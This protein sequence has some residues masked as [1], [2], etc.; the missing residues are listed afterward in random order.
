M[1]NRANQVLFGI[2]LVSFAIYSVLFAACFSELPIH[3]S[4]L[5]QGFV[6]YFHMIPMFFLQLLLCRLEKRRWWLLLPFLPIVM[7]GILFL[8]AAEWDPRA[9]VIVALWCVAPAVGYGLAW[10]AY[11]LTKKKEG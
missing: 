6:F 4:P 8:G 7:A 10:A 5:H 2:F 9:W 1:K 11:R 3:I